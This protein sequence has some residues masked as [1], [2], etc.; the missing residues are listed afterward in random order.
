MGF[1]AQIPKVPKSELDAVLRNLLNA[2]PMPM[3]DIPR[4]RPPQGR[5]RK[6]QKRG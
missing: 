3:S 4:K 1:V 6:P 5:D 2:A